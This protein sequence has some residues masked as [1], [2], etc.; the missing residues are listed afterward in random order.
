MPFFIC[1]THRA[2]L[3]FAQAF[4]RGWIVAAKDS[5]KQNR[6]VMISMGL[7]LMFGAFTA[8]TVP[9]GEY[10]PQFYAIFNIVLDATMTV[11][12]VFLLVSARATPPGG[13]KP[14]A[15][16]IGAVGV[17]A[18]ALKVLIRFTSDHA[19]WT[20]NYLPPVFN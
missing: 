9:A 17:L 12:L 14:V 11:F 18:G 19:W 10:P 13:L 15:R 4:S 2:G 5:A 3:G 6:Y 20:G 7:V 1:W 8:M 16:L